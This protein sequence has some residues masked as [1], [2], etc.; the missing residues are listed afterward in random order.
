MDLIYFW[1][2]KYKNIEATGF[3][4]SSKAT[5]STKIESTDPDDTLNLTLTVEKESLF[6]IFPENVIDVKAVLGQNGS[7]KSNLLLWIINFLMNGHTRD[8]GFLVT[9]EFIIV[10]DKINFTQ[11]PQELLGK[12]LKLVEPHEII[13]FTR[14]K[15]KKQVS[16][17]EAFGMKSNNLM[18]TYFKK[19]YLISYSP[20]FNQD[21]IYNSEGVKNSYFRWENST[22]NFFDISTESLMIG[23][24]NN[25]KV[26]LEY[27]ISGES[28]LLSFKSM[29]SVRELAFLTIEKQ[30]DLNIKFPIH[31]IDIDFT[32]FN[33]KFWESID[34]L[35]SGN[36]KDQLKIETLLNFLR[37]ETLRLNDRDAFLTEF[38]KEIM[39]CIMSFQ[40]NDNINNS[41]SST[42]PLARLIV[43]I[44]KNYDST[45]PAYE[46]LYKYI[47]NSNNFSDEQIHLLISQIS[48]AKQYF[49]E[50][51][52]SE[53]IICRGMYGLTVTEEN[54]IQIISDFQQN[55]MRELKLHEDS[56]D[57]DEY[58]S[59]KL[60]IFGF[61]LHGLSSGERN[62]LSLFS[63]LNAIKRWIKKDRDIL[64][65]IDEGELGFHP[66]WQ[67]EYLN[68]LIDFLYKFFPQNKVQLIITSHSPFLA[69][70]LPKENII[71]LKR[72]DNFK[73]RIS[74]L[75]SHQ[76]TFASN[77][78]SLY[79]D[80]FFLQGATIGSFS[81]EILNEIIEYLKSNEFS[82]I[83]NDKYREIIQIIG[84]P[85][86]KRKMEDLWMQKLGVE[87][88]IQ[89]LKKRIK[90]LE[91]L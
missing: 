38:S 7:G 51:I 77:I 47:E 9:S 87:E 75:E 8:F 66:Q 12:E 91:S 19:K 90:H 79:S 45:L 34:M 71:F 5:L 89:M 10:R 39:Y 81:K 63:R 43:N 67:K 26:N 4:L 74:D 11:F 84:E 25:H 44:E 64:F 31:N 85:V 46:A 70:D 52:D 57:P 60:N 61:N 13:N 48:A 21:N 69:S 32:G 14:G 27:M 35:F 49:E 22:L 37:F 82:A 80:A 16:K 62:F 86:I 30:L 1:I 53:Q 65:L 17:E 28:E 54:L 36:V 50:K 15:Y 56:G 6:N 2:R 78:H 33:S 18:E 73:T 76:L 24:Y 68:I 55:P 58:L 3:N 42:A 29:E 83:K 40:L 20:G 41:M 23:D 72:D 88:E 59:L